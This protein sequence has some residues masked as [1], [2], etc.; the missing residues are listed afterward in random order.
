M[1][2]HKK[3]L[4]L[5]PFALTASRF[6]W[7]GGVTELVLPYKSLLSLQSIYLAVYLPTLFPEKGGGC[8]SLC[9]DQFQ[10]QEDKVLWPASTGNTGKLIPPRN[11]WKPL[12]SEVRCLEWGSIPAP[13]AWVPYSRVI[14]C[15]H[16]SENSDR[17]TQ[18]AH[19]NSLAP[20]PPLT[21][22]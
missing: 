14:L 15:K 5:L 16:A 10:A 11:W 8:W 6:P 3:I 18:G 20:P 13:G 12:L 4:P 2:V 21:S 1:Q 22:L 9:K 17:V 19:K 7:G